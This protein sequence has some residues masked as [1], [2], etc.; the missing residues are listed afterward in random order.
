MRWTYM[1]GVFF[2]M[3]LI[4]GAAVLSGAS[5][6]VYINLP[7]FL[8]VIGISG[9]I[10]LFSWD[11][12]TIG[13]CF[14]AVFSES[15]TEQDIKLGIVF[16][17]ALTKYFFLSAAIGTGTGLIAIL[18]NLSDNHAIGQ[19]VALALLCTYYSLVLTLLVTLPFGTS[20]KRRLAEREDS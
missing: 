19:V 16:F 2:T 7:S 12:R 17:P 15:A 4:W 1:W 9:V 14:R 13:R 11:L 3:G 5:I 6:A 10:T 20:L 8:M 18:A